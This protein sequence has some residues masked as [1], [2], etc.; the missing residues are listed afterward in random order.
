MILTFV[1]SNDV[2][3]PESLRDRRCIDRRE[4]D[5]HGRWFDQFNQDAVVQY[6]PVGTPHK[7]LLSGFSTTAAMPHAGVH[8]VQRYDGGRSTFIYGE[9]RHDGLTR[10][11]A[12]Q[13]FGIRYFERHGHRHSSSARLPH[14]VPAS[15]AGCHINRYHATI[16]LS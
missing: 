9:H 13:Q 15:L 8:G 11:Q 10:L 5:G 16:I 14:R 3:R 6:S 2:H 7:K 1:E 12:L 4:A